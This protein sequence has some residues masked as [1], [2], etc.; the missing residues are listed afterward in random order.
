M[1]VYWG[2]KFLLDEDLSVIKY[3]K[4]HEKENDDHPTVS[5]CLRNPFSRQG[6]NN[7]E[8]TSA[9]YLKYLTRLQS[10]MVN[11]VL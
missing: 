6:L 9:L 3:R 5:F 8:V 10:F 11:G 7:H 1:C 2:Y 4:F